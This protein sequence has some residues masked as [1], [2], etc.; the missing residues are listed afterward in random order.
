MLGAPGAGK[1][2]QAKMIA[3]KYDIPHISTGDMLRQAVANK[4]PIGVKA[5]EYMDAGDLVPDEVIMGIIAET[6]TQKGCK[7]GFILDGIPRT[8][9]QASTLD[10]I[11]KNLSLK[12]TVAFNFYISDD[13]IIKRLSG[14]RMCTCGATYHTINNPSK[15]DD[16]CDVCSGKLYQRDDDKEAV[17][18]NRLEVYRKKT[19]PLVDYYKGKNILRNI[20]SDRDLNVVFEEVCKVLDD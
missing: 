12:F 4:T 18:R 2:T 8:V 19:E 15:R 9:I 3:S 17:V 13:T 5:K 16:L 7:K 11:M 20:D 10:A 14:R 6:I 1:G